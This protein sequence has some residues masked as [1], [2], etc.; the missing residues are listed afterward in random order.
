MSKKGRWPEGGKNAVGN[1]DQGIEEDRA[2]WEAHQA[3]IWREGCK[4][5]AMIGWAGK[6]GVISQRQK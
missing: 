4:R 1:E 6:G 5:G 3:P 2:L